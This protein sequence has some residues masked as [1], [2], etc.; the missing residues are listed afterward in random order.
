MQHFHDC[1]EICC[2]DTENSRTGIFVCLMFS[3]GRVFFKHWKQVKVTRDNI[4]RI[5][6]LDNI[7]LFQKGSYNNRLVRW[8]IVIQKLFTSETSY[9]LTFFEI[10][11]CHTHTHTHLPFDTAIWMAGYSLEKEMTFHK[12]FYAHCACYYARSLA[13]LGG[14]YFVQGLFA[15]VH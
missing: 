13:L 5:M 10:F 12:L 3:S 8:S 2:S 7:F 9:W 1:F 14:L 4:L 6:R 15:L 11:I